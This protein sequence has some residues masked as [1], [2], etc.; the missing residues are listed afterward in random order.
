M[1]IINYIL[2]LVMNGI[3]NLSEDECNHLFIPLRIA[4]EEILTEKLEIKEKRV[5]K[6]K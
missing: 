3:H 2:K 5:G 4:I 6:K 1:D